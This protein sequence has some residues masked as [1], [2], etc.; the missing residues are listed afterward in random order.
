MENPTVDQSLEFAAITSVSPEVHE[1][2]KAACYDCHSNETIYPWYSHVA[3]FSWIIAD[4]VIEGR[5]ELNFS[6]WGTYSLK[7]QDHKLEE[8]IE[9]VEEGEMP[10]KGYV[11]LHS[12]ADLTEEQTEAVFSWI[13]QYRESLDVPEE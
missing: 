11:M 4:H 3:P 13:R 7:R 2:I 1:V 10:M 6:E 9:E 5:D 12:E 8:M